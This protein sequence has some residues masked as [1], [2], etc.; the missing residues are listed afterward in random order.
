MFQYSITPRPASIIVDDSPLPGKRVIVNTVCYGQQE[1][2][3][4]N[5][6]ESPYWGEA[7]ILRAYVIGNGWSDYI[8]LS[9]LVLGKDTSTCT[10]CG[11]DIS[12]PLMCAE[13]GYCLG[14][15]VCPTYEALD[16]G[17][18]YPDTGDD[19]AYDEYHDRRA[20][21]RLGDGG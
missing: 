13:C 18:D 19:A 1:G 6:C 3:I 5:I 10:Q 21:M 8:R 16:D 4:I 15:C 7:G 2:I 12:R 9:E 20:I 17:W 11:R 14:C